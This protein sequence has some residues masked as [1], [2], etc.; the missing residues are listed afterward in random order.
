[1]NPAK[2][3]DAL[4][5]QHQRLRGMFDHARAL[6]GGERGGAALAE[7]LAE[8]GRALV[9][10]NRYEESV[11]RPM[12]LAQDAWGGA[13]VDRMCEEHAGEH[14]AFVERLAA[15]GEDAAELADLIEE[16]EAHMAAE[17]RVF[18]NIAVLRDR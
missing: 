7:L 16:V 13:R 12:L 8:L 14:R 3:R 1:M 10:H 9:E 2:I 11:L 15:A 5:T 4:L 18:L 6:A 17:E